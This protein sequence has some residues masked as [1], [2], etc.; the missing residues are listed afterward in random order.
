MGVN[1]IEHII[2][3]FDIN[4]VLESFEP[5]GNGHI[6]DTFIL[7]FKTQNETESYVLQRINANVFKK[8]LDVIHN[9]KMQLLVR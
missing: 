4:G 2:K 9:I 5:F 6:N 8:P 3:Q 1:N 7:K